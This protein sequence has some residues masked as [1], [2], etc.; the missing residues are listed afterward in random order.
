MVSLQESVESQLARGRGYFTKSNSLAETQQTPEAFQAAI[1]RLK[2]KGSVVSP[3]RGF[4]LILRPEDRAL[5]A[6][7]P[8]RWIDPLMSYLKVDYRISL[9]RAAAVHGS[10][11]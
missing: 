2:K 5:G 3:R 4:F 1:A 9:L 10:T 6:P 8:A 11:H 7:D